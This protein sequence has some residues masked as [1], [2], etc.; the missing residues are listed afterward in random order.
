[1]ADLGTISSFISNGH[2]SLPVY[3][4]A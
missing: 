4:G 2:G 1:P 3:L